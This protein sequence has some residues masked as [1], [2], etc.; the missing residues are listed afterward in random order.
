M[1]H[2]MYSLP[3]ALDELMPKMSAE[4]LQYHHGKHLQTYVDNL[5]KLIKDTPEEQMQLEDLVRQSSGPIFN[6][7]AQT[8]N[9]IFFFE[10]LTPQPQA[11]PNELEAA[12]IND[13]GS[14]STFKDKLLSSA[15][16]LFGAGWTWLVINKEGH[17]EIVNTSNAGNPMRDGMKPLLTIDVWE[18]AYYIDYRNRRAEYLQAVWD[19]INWDTVAK[20]LEACEC[21]IYI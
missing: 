12:I 8:W 4:T 5:N 10:A 13:F 3:Y 15:T 7:A 18:H 17:L 9:H 16:T 11:I 2:I 20:R 6:N 1:K 19:L 21:N 14:T